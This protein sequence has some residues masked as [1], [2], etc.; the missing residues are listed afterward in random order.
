MPDEGT[1]FRVDLESG[2]SHSFD[3]PIEAMAFSVGV[4]NYG[5]RS[6]IVKVDPKRSM[7]KSIIDWCQG[8]RERVD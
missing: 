4:Q 1:I 6:K 3:D 7:M 8:I 2:T 5:F